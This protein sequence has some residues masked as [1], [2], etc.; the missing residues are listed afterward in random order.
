[1]YPL[2][3]PHKRK[4]SLEE[5]RVLCLRWWNRKVIPGMFKW[6][7][8]IYGKFESTREGATLER[9]WAAG[10]RIDF[11]RGGKVKPTKLEMDLFA[12]QDTLP[13][14]KAASWWKWEDG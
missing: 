13:M 14:V 10:R 7:G 11:G 5:F 6:I 4:I 12:L 1:M 2:V 3:L 8:E 9:G